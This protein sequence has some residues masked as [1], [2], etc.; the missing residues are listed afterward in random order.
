MILL[1]KLCFSHLFLLFAF[2]CSFH[3][4]FAKKKHWHDFQD[5]QALLI[6]RATPKAWK[7]TLSYQSGP[8]KVIH[9]SANSSLT[10]EKKMETGK[11]SLFQP[12]ETI[13]LSGMENGV[14]QTQNLLPDMRPGFWPKIQRDGLG[15]HLHTTLLPLE[16]VSFVL[17]ILLDIV[18]RVFFWKPIICCLLQN[19]DCPPCFFS[20]QF[21]KDN[22]N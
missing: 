20:P 21:C 3:F 6:S 5:W 9:L 8:Q 14:F 17:F 19:A 2:T 13:V 1:Q 15:H 4:N 16:L 22:P 10:G 18:S 11:F 7:Q 12:T